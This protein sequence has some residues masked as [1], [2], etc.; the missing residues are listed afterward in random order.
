MVGLLLG[1]GLGLAVLA[2]RRGNVL[3]PRIDLAGGC[4]L[5]VAGVVTVSAG[6]RRFAGV[7]L[8]AAAG[9]WFLVTADLGGGLTDRLMYLHRALLVHALL[10]SSGRA[11]AVHVAVVVAAYAAS[12]D[13]GRATSTAWLTGVGGA[14]VAVLVADVV[15][16]ESTWGFAF[17]ASSGVLLWSAAAG[18]LL[19]ND[20]FEPA[21]RSALYGVGLGL[22]ASAIAASEAGLLAKPGAPTTADIVAR[23]Q[24]AEV[25]IGLRS[26]DGTEFEDIGGQ[27]FSFRPGEVTARIELG[28]DLGEAVVAVPTAALDVARAQRQLTEGLRLLAANHRALQV[29]RSQAAEVAASEERIRE[30]DEHAASQIGLELDRLVVQ[31]INEALELVAEHQSDAGAEARTGLLEVRAEV[32]ALAAGLSPTA[33]DGGLRGALAHLA[34]QQPLPVEARLDDIRVEPPVARALYF[35]A[36]ECLTNAVR[37]ASASRLRLTLRERGADAELTVTDDGCG[38]AR[39]TPGGGLAGLAARL[40]SLGGDFTLRPGEQSGTVVTVHLPLVTGSS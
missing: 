26:P 13:P 31:R 32:Q 15:R 23:R 17:P 22:A 21:V 3:F 7:L 14:T 19:R 20:V 5:L 24:P 4:S 27:P 18:I 9:S 11:T 29:T 33:L 16:R 10:R 2:E 6:G 34:H 36:A 30:A 8:L 28:G 25:R 12:V 40:E 37:H 38:G 1:A 39:K 35:A